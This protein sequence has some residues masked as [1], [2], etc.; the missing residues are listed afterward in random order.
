LRE[1][2]CSEIRHVIEAL[3]HRAILHRSFSI[4][5]A[6]KELQG[7]VVV[8]ART[9][10]AIVTIRKRGQLAVREGGVGLELRQGAVAFGRL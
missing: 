4:G 7:P 8:L 3:D 10:Q 1:P 6:G 2:D 5:V 9:V